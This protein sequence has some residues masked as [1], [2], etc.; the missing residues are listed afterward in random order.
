MADAPGREA[1]DGLPA[2]QF[3]GRI[4][5]DMA[6]SNPNVVYAFMDNYEPGR[7]PREGER[8]AYTRPIFEGAH[9]VS[10]DVPHRRQ[11]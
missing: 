8:D 2:A 9:Q 10:R 5:L 3:R 1:N 4:G 6:R 11:G 7:P